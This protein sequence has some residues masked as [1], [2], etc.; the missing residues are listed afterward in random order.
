MRSGIKCKSSAVFIFDASFSRVIN[1]NGSYFNQFKNIALNLLDILQ[2]GDDRQ[3]SISG[4]EEE[5]TKLSTNISEL[6]NRVNKLTTG[7]IHGA[8][9]KAIVQAARLLEESKNFNKEIYILSD[10]QR[11]SF[12]NINAK[13][14]LSELLDERVRIYSFEF[15][16]KMPFNLGIDEFKIVK[17]Q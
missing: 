13:T 2:E 4:S 7:Y 14:D 16:E 10:L 15:P 3:L 17:K 5:E 6:K 9:D 11:S 1:K 8:L 12:L